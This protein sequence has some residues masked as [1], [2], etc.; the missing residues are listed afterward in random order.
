MEQLVLPLPTF[1]I[2]GAQKSATRWLRLNLGL[3]PDVFTSSREIEFFN[4]GDR[5]DEDGEAW[6][7]QQFPDYPRARKALVPFLY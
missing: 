4:N 3:H 5:F 7:R 6:Y 2:I 1:L